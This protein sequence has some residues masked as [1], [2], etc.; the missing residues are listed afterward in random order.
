MST[1][2]A[3]TAHVDLPITG[4]S[5]ASCAAHVEQ[6]LNGLP[7]VS[8]VVNLA[9]EK[10]AVDFDPERVSTH[11]LVEAVASA[12]YGASAPAEEADRR[13]AADAAAAAETSWL[14]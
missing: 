14:R 11:E 2:P 8:A 10:A 6:R 4:M 3:T 12:G 1:G 5:C 13:G 7:G 9:T